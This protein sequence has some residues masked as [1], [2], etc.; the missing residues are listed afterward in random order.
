MLIAATVSAVAATG[1]AHGGHQGRPPGIIDPLITHHAVLEDELELNH[2][3]IRVGEERRTTHRAS[4]ELAYALTDLVGA[5]LFVPFGVS[6]AGGEAR[7]GLGDLDILLPK[8][9][10]VR[11]RSIVMT[12]YVA[13]RA[14]TGSEEA[15]LGE[16]AWAFAPHLLADLGLGNLGLQTNLA[17]EIETDGSVSLEGRPRERQKAPG[18]VKK[19]VIITNIVIQ[20]QDC[21][22]SPRSSSDTAPPT[23]SSTTPS[24]PTCSATTRLGGAGRCCTGR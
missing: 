19:C 18:V 11:E 24:S 17:T 5:E 14:P 9:S 13:V 2:D 8:L 10:F 1:V 22:P 6:I 16:P 4:L 15:A 3:G 7:G 21:R 23:A 12:S 20:A